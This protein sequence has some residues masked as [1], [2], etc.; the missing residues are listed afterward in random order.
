MDLFAKKSFITSY[1]LENTLLTTLSAEVLKATEL[2]ALENSS[3][4]HS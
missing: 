4:K 3:V 1:G 2:V